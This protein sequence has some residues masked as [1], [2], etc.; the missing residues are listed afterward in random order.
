MP[1]H[2]NFARALPSE[3]ARARIIQALGYVAIQAA[4]LA[5][6]S[7]LIQASPCQPLLAA[8]YGYCSRTLITLSF[9][10]TFFFNLLNC[11]SDLCPDFHEAT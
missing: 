5:K 4:L 3:G 9:V 11:N 7:R 10:T 2:R 8:N 1:A 6:A